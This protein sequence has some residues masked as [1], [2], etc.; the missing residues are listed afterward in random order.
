MHETVFYDFRRKLFSLLYPNP[1]EK[2]SRK[3]YKH[4]NKERGQVPKNSK[5]IAKNARKTVFGGLGQK[6]LL[7]GSVV[8]ESTSSF[9]FAA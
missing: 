7:P 6:S 4:E 8:L 9:N 1:V 2:L 3:N 5:K